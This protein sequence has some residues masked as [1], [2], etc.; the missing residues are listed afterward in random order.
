MSQ[1]TR[2]NKGE[3]LSPKAYAD[4]VVT[5]F[6]T[7]AEKT[8]EAALFPYL[9]DAYSR[10]TGKPGVPGRL[11]QFEKVYQW[12]EQSLKDREGISRPHPKSH[13]LQSFLELYQNGFLP[14]RAKL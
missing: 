5:K 1:Q 14:L 12:A 13:G 4:L 11:L 2:C 10:I 7:K 6:T 8:Y 9:V 3:P